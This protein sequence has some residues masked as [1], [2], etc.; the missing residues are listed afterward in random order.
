MNIGDDVNNFSAPQGDELL[1]K[2]AKLEHEI[3]ELKRRLSEAE[4]Q[5]RAVGQ[6]E[7]DRDGEYGRL[8]S[9]FFECIDK[10]G[11]PAD[12]RSEKKAA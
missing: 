9:Y 6:H 11:L 3:R 10:S 5:A 4:A 8:P 12:Q 2:F 1:E 7:G